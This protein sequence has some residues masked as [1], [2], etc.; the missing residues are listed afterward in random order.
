MICIPKTN[1]DGTLHMQ[2][3]LSL[4]NISYRTQQGDGYIQLKRNMTLTKEL[5]IK[6]MKKIIKLIQ[7]GIPL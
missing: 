5:S 6:I 7:E 2:I 3:G 1:T 4:K